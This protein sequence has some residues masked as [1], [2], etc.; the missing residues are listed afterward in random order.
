MT[1]AARA[2]A[3]PRIRPS[4]EPAPRHIEVVATRDQR[5]AR[6]RTVYA[7]IVVGGLFV[8]L[9]AQL[10][11]SIGLSDGAYAISSLQQQ[12]RE[13]DRTHQALTEDVDRLSS[14]QNLARNAQALGMVAS[15]SP[16]FLSL[17]GTV[18]GTP[19]AKDGATTALTADTLI[20]NSLLAGVPLTIEADP[21][22]RAA[23]LKAATSPDAGAAVDPGSAIPGSA[24]ATGGVTAGTPS[25]PPA[26]G[27]TSGLAS[28]TAIPT[29]KTR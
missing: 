25:A 10:M 27:A 4:A 13:L 1:D 19:Q 14:P 21:A 8:L 12:Q 20:G 16:S 3:R 24:E 18:Q 2:T 6:P 7:L 23:A 29:P 11:L 26:D 15:A 9:L 5:R 28:A 17:D 22:K